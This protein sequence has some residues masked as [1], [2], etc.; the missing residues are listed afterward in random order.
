MPHNF[1]PASEG[2]TT[3][4]GASR[5]G[6]RREP[7]TDADVADWIS[8][9][10]AEGISRVVCLLCDCQDLLAAYGAAFGTDNVLHAPIEDFMLAGPD[11]LRPIMRFL[12][13]SDAAGQRVV[14]HC[15]AG[16][17]RTGQVMAAWLVA[18]RGLTAT[19]A[20]AAVE[21]AHPRRYP[22]E[23]ATYGNATPEQ[24]LALLRTVGEAAA[25]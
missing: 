20:I 11:G 21:Q 23:A 18:G 14:V 2:E 5:P 15:A 8:F 17:G 12:A 6:Y 3:V 4:F 24:L 13:E 9:M 1:G 16:A 22:M 25:E 19:V 7:A 10:Q